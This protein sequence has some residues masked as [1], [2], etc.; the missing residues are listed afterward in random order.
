[1]ENEQATEQTAKNLP[2]GPLELLTGKGK[3]VTML[4]SV[5][6]LHS[7]VPFHRTKEGSLLVP[8]E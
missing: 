6:P 7:L 4:A 8:M 2:G 1:M 3:T 5:S